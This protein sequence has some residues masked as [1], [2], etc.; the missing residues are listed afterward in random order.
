[1]PSFA[2]LLMRRIAIVGVLAMLMLVSGCED[3][4][5]V[6]A[7]PTIDTRA[8][9]PVMTSPQRGPLTAG[10]DQTLVVLDVQGMDC[11]GCEG[12]VR[13][14]LARVP[15]VDQV[16]V[17]HHAGK[18]WVLAASDAAPDQTLLITAVQEMGDGSRYKAALA[19]ATP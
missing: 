16:S 10:E 1:M 3:R 2:S 8:N 12:A 18:A 6:L 15:G 13:S 14:V 5:E 4:Q 17:S 9:P 11:T 19:Q 7:P